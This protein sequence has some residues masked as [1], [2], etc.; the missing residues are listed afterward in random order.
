MG[1]A[2]TSGFDSRI[3]LAA[4]RGHHKDFFL[5]TMQFRKMTKDSSDISVP[6]AILKRIRSKHHVI[7]CREI[8][9]P[10]FLKIY[11]D[12]VELAHDDWSK[13]NFG[14]YKAFPQDH[15]LLKGNTSEISRTYLF[16]RDQGEVT[17]VN[18]I[19]SL[20]PDWQKIEF[21][22]DNL[23]TWFRDARPV[24]KKYGVHILDLFFW[25]H[26]IGSWYAQ[27]LNELDIVHE[28][29]SP[30]S[31][32][33]MLEVMLGVPARYRSRDTSEL[34]YQI[35]G[36]LWPQLTYWPINPPNWN[37]RRMVKYKAASIL[38][39]TG[40]YEPAF[41]LY[42]KLHPIYMKLKRGR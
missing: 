11:R 28:T 14:M 16:K 18:E 34:H 35:L 37:R 25:E 30:F 4:S 17:S 27:N 40:L 38:K 13:L 12:N 32:R 33:P 5:H 24:C 39:K 22:M 41:S 20:W 3:I 15:V 2:L 29:F 31:Y 10:E 36:K 9:D 7:E 6:R 21:I 1:I 26:R 42:K 19:I 8:P 23:N